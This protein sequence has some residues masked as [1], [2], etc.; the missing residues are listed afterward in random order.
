MLDFENMTTTLLFLTLMIPGTFL[1]GLNDVLVRRLLKSGAIREQLLVTYEFIGVF[2]V[3]AVPLLIQGVPEIKPG[4]WSAILITAVLN[5]F[6]Q[7]AWYTAFRKEEA[8]L[9]SP[10]R[11]LTPPLVLLT[12]FYF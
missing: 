1:L 7:W 12:G 9:I 2:V 11:L 5:I 6:A 4:F 8:S 3:L 10:L